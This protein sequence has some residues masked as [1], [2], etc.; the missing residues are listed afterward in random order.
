MK[1]GQFIFREQPLLFPFSRIITTLI[2]VEIMKKASSGMSMWLRSRFEE[3]G[4]SVTFNYDPSPPK[5]RHFGK[6]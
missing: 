1:G 3:E 6:L 5:C 4:G 2:F